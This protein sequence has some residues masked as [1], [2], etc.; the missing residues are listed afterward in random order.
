LVYNLGLGRDAKPSETDKRNCNTQ[1]QLFHHFSFESLELSLEATAGLGSIPHICVNNHPQNDY[2]PLDALRPCNSHR[3]GCNGFVTASDGF[4]HPFAPGI[5]RA[6]F[7]GHFGA[8]FNLFLFGCDVV[9][10]FGSGPRV[11]KLPLS[12]I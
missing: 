7:N 1:A 5:A 8:I 6:D 12:R 11:C 9:I 2:R 4:P 3:T 10:F